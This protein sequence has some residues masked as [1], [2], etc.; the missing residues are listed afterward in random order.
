MS[1][2]RKGAIKMEIYTKDPE[3]EKAVY[4]K[5]RSIVALVHKYLGMASVV[6]VSKT[7]NPEIFH[8]SI[9]RD[10]MFSDKD[11]TKKIEQK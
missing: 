3:S 2:L 11:F 10:N 1:R 9:S 8:L 7:D 5:N 6:E 4:R